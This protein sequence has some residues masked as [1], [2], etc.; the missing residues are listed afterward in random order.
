[1]TQKTS[2][3]KIWHGIVQTRGE[4]IKGY[5]SQT[6]VIIK[7]CF[8]QQAV[9]N[10]LQERTIYMNNE[11]AIFQAAFIHASPTEKERQIQ[12]EISVF[13]P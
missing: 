4:V 2:Y 11:Q 9:L 3:Y 13:L 1:M 5:Q 6:L 8:M 12:Q 10:T 7:T